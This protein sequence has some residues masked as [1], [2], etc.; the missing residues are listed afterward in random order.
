MRL[1]PLTKKE[2]N[3]A[4]EAADTL[5]WFFRGTYQ[6]AIDDFEDARTEGD[7]DAAVEADTRARAFIAARTAISVAIRQISEIETEGR[8]T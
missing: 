4:K 1:T 3:D 5:L 2:I 6:F 7:L 8:W